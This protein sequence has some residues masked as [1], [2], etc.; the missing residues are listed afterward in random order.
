MYAEKKYQKAQ[1]A[2]QKAVN[3][4]SASFAANYNLSNAYYKQ[5]K[6]NKSEEL[7]N[8][9]IQT[10]VDT[11]KLADLNY[12]LGNS[13]VMQAPKL[14]KEKKMD[15]GLKF[16]KSGLKAYKNALLKNPEDKKA[17]YNY[18]KTKEIIKK[19]E[20]EQQNNK[21]QEHSKDN[22]D[23]NEN[24]KDNKEQ[25]KENKGDKENQNKQN[26]KNKN[27]DDGDGIPNEVEQGNEQKPRDTD[28]DGKPDMNDKDSDNDGIPDSYEAGEDPTNP[29]DDDNDGLPNY[30]DTDSDN[31]NIPDNEDPDALP[32]A[33]KISD[34]DAEMW[35]R[36]IE[37]QE[38]AVQK[39]LKKHKQMKSSSSKEKDW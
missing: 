2:Y 5:D 7:L 36:A 32:K 34:K 16:L 6:Y 23:Q 22:K 13:L 31:D 24:N 11:K 29:K 21:N 10:T 28:N 37:K 26:G 35:L 3:T 15:E 39:K 17:K 14:L 18:I 33:M 4:D 30:R 19:L 12:N 8:K 20:Q 9:L 27:D 38:Q 1:V 25:D